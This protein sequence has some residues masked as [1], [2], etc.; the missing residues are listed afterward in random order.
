MYY[1]FV[2][3]N[4]AMVNAKTRMSENRQIK[5]LIITLH[6][7]LDTNKLMCFWFCRE[8]SIKY[9]GTKK[10]QKKIAQLLIGIAHG[11]ADTWTASKFISIAKQIRD[12]HC[13]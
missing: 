8:K 10:A 11:Q 2:F 4:K 13:S 5:E 3:K 9:I 12:L 1:T 7:Y 6:E